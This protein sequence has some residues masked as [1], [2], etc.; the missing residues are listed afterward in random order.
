M[1]GRQ[2]ESGFLLI[3]HNEP[4]IKLDKVMF[5]GLPERPIR[6]A[7]HQ[8]TRT[9]GLSFVELEDNDQARGDKRQDNRET[10]VCPTPVCF[11]EFFR[12]FCSGV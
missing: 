7:F 11:V 1:T 5:G 12:N 9:H 3:K 2:L 6:L 4:T 8:H 10:S